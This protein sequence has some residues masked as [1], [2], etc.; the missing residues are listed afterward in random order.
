MPRPTA[1]TFFTAEEQQRIEAA[2]Q[3]AEKKTS[4]EIVPMVVDAAFDY[5]RAE[6]FGGG[7]F[8]LGTAVLCSWW[9]GH[10]SVWVFL[11]IFLA[12]YLPCKWLIRALP[13]LKRRFIPQQVL[14]EEVEEKALVAFLEHGLHATRDQTGILILLSLFER[15]V[16]VLADRGINAR[17]D[18]ATWDEIVDSVTS[19]IRAGRACDSLCAAVARCGELLQKDFPRK[20]DDTDEL[21]NLIL[22]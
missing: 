8:S 1:K 3:A 12:G 21:P 22:D 4:G 9:F 14:A 15:R 5:P 7:F 20:A 18:K 13:A 11:P 6:I 10:S 16:H 2:V 19:G 17:V